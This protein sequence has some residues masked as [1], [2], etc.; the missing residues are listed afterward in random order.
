MYNKTK[1]EVMIVVDLQYDEV[2]K[3]V[4]GY[5]GLYQVSS[6]GNIKILGKQ[7]VDCGKG[8]TVRKRYFKSRLM[9][10]Q[11]NAQGYYTVSLTKDRRQHNKLVSRLVAEAFIPNPNNLP[12]VNHKDENPKN[13]SVSNLEWCT[14]A[15][16]N[17]YGTIC[18]RHRDMMLGK[19]RGPHS[20]ETRLKISKSISEWHK[21][22]RIL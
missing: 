3:D 15:Y 14:R 4:V 2:W 13:N 1:S 11:V 6:L 9:R 5:E 19:K 12:C 8:G 17:S 21:A 10:L 22:R 16:N 18:Q 7:V 20:E